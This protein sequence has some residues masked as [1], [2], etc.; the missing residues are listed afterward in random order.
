MTGIAEYNA[1]EFA[2]YAEK[3][4]AQ[5]LKILSPPELD[6][7]DI[8][9]PYEYYIRRDVRVLLHDDVDRIYLLK[10]WQKS[11]GAQ[12][13]VHLAR[14][15]KI[16]IYDAESGEPYT[17]NVA[18]E[19]IR[20]VY[21]DRRESYNN[22]LSDFSRTAAIVNA[23]LADKLKTPINAEDV[24]LFMIGV[25]LS[26]L[27]NKRDH[28]DSLVDILGYGLCFEWVQELQRGNNDKV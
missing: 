26:R 12:L 13:E 10:G 18:E 25:K 17:E 14:M 27:S 19:A 1:P 22:P 20:L 11:R 5:G 7:G 3:Y 9:K 24:A 16:P 6:K 23:V 15:F 2:K 21:G 8:S 4:R 28:R